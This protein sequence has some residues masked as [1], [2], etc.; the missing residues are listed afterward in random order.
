M[1][2]AILHLVNGDS[3]TIEIG[4][5]QID[6]FYEEWSKRGADTFETIE[7]AWI[8]PKDVLWIEFLKDEE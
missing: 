2:K 8:M 4:D 1:Y 7:D 6:E 3:F 5:S